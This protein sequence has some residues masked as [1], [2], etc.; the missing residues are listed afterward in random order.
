MFRSIINKFIW[1]Y[2][3]GELMKFKLNIFIPLFC[4]FFCIYSFHF[5]KKKLARDTP[6]SQNNLFKVPGVSDNR[7]VLAYNIQTLKAL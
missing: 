4:L 5:K 2:S 7:V 1:I 3:F 6:T